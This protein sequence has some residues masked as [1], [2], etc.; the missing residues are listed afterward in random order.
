MLMH[1]K[2]CVPPI[3][4]HTATPAILHSRLPCLCNVKNIS[5]NLITFNGADKVCIYD[6]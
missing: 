5:F 3:M 2:T 6:N 4:E 1:E